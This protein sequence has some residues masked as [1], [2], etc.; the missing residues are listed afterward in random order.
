MSDD[1]IEGAE[2]LDIFDPETLDKVLFSDLK[3]KAEDELT[4]KTLIERRRLAY[5]AV[6]SEGYRTQLDIDIVLHDL[7][8][9]CRAYSSTFDTREGVH[10]DTLAKMKEGRREVFLRVK[11][12]A[13]LDFDSVFLKYTDALTKTF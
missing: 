1:F 11:D 2:G 9:F 13:S 4:V 12:F 6:F 10:A 5:A 3:E 8:W 7:A